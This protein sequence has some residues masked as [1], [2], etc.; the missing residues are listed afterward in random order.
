MQFKSEKKQLRTR[1]QNAA[2]I[3]DDRRDDSVALVLRNC[4]PSALPACRALPFVRCR[5][6]TVSRVSMRCSPVR[7]T[8]IVTLV[9]KDTSALVASAAELVTQR[10]GAMLV[11][12]LRVTCLLGTSVEASL[13]M[14]LLFP[15][16]AS[17]AR[18]HE[19]KRARVQRVVMMNVVPLASQRSGTDA[20]VASLSRW[21][22]TASWFCRSLRESRFGLSV[23]LP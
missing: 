18:A 21:P 5:C 12:R 17:G 2:V 23:R 9:E 16:S 20:C 1:T 19:V 10:R 6:R 3:G 8:A 15:S 11:R 4:I 13:V 14:E 22:S 7:S